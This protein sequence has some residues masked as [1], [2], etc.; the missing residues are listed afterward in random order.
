M[1][2]LILASVLLGAA[3]LIL[4]TL[5]RRELRR[6]ERAHRAHVESFV[7]WFLDQ[8]TAVR[9]DGLNDIGRQRTPGY[10]CAFVYLEDGGWFE[11]G[12]RSADGSGSW[13]LSLR[14]VQGRS[15]ECFPPLGLRCDAPWFVDRMHELQRVIDAW[16][17]AWLGLRRALCVADGLP[18]PLLVPQRPN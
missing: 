11:L 3:I 13:S 18:D 7:A 9:K 16:P 14:N 8:V 6:A 4:L 1:D 17:R 5:H 10:E 2:H 12:I 15:L